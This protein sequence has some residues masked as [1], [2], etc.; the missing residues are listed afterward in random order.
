MKYIILPL[1][2]HNLP[3]TS[4]KRC[5]YVKGAAGFLPVFYSYSDAVHWYEDS[6]DVQQRRAEIVGKE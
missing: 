5:E 2:E 1:D 3:M 4:A 6:I